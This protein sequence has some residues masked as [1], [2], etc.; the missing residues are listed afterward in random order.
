MIKKPGTDAFSSSF[1]L[2]ASVVVLL[3]LYVANCFTPLRLTHDTIRYFQI[4]TWMEN[5]LDGTE[6]TMHDFLPFGYSGLLLLLSI[7][8]LLHPFVIT[9]INLAFLIGS[10]FFVSKI[11]GTMIS[12]LQLLIAVLLSWL[13]IKFVIT[14]LSE[15]QFLYF[16]TGALYFYARYRKENRIVL[17]FVSFLFFLIA[18]FTR[19]IAIALIIAFLLTL[20]IESKN[21][22]RQQIATHK[23]ISAVIAVGLIA[24]IYFFKELRITVYANYFINPIRRLGPAILMRNVLHHLSDWAELFVNAPSSKISFLSGGLRLILFAII[25]IIFLAATIYILLKKNNGIPSVIK[26]YV[27]IYIIIV[28]T[29]P[30]YESRFWLPVMPFAIVAL[31]QI[32]SERTTMPGKLILL[33]KYF[34]VLA[35]V[36]ALSYYTYTSFNK[37]ALAEKQDAGIWK[38]AYEIHFFGKTGEDSLPPKKQQA[39]DLLN[40]IDK[41]LFR[42]NR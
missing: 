13:S 1:L 41:P 31:L 9:F 38:D 24:L 12:Q 17:L 40:Q 16:S 28:L 21:R 32:K 10:I 7:T 22:I 29:W 26:C 34:Y 19:S 37:K 3:L 42:G 15:M 27:I 35:G 8:H 36:F 5:R 25:G 39:L 2:Q 4:E 6:G 11:F 18:L 20:L 30:Y 23:K 14:P 33:A